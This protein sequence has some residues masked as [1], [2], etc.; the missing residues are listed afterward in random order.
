MSLFKSA[1]YLAW[2][3]TRAR[4]K[5][6]VLGPWWLTFGNVIGIVGLSLVWA[7][8]LNETMSSFIPSLTIGMVTWQLVAG[9]IG[10][11]PTTF[12]RHASII[13]NVVIP[14]W[15][16]VARALFRQLI[17]LLHNLVII[18][19][20]LVVFHVHVGPVAL[21]SVVGLALVIANLYWIIF[22]MAMLGA[23][24]RDIE[25]LT[26]S[27][28]PLLFFVSPVVFRPNRISVSLRIIWL[29]P[30]SHFIEVVRAPLLGAPAPWFSYV[31]MIAMLVIGSS[32]TI[33]LQ[34]SRGRRLAFW[35]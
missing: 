4:Y 19:G 16:F 6:S 3:D 2:S 18:I 5:K 24:F 29:N 17:N 15:F 34:R 35:I 33:L 28:L 10:E 26:N 9:A 7:R 12:V 27:L 1:A 21:L 25:Y 13:R 14:S 8:L 22:L 30:L 31:V 23:R 11:A 32:L 20:V